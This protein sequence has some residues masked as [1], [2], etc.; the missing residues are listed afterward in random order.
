MS[1]RGGRI[2]AALLLATWFASSI[3]AAAA[4]PSIA[5][6]PTTGAPGTKVTVTGSGFPV[7]EVVA[8]Y[9]DSPQPYLGMP[10]PIADAQGSFRQDFA[11]PGKGYDLTGH[12]NAGKAGRHTVCADT[13]YPGS[14]Q[15]VAVK[16][17]VQFQ[18]GSVTP[19]AHGANLPGVP[20]TQVV[21]AIA[22]L[23]AIALGA[24]LW[25]RN[26]K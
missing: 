16:V 3:P 7:G 4:E 22:L 2:L 25:I 10:G 15:A 13:G 5:V 11:W 17:C 9:V 26:A 19:A 12:I 24:A 6:S 21:F 8:L 23:A 20:L 1:M 18:V 14:S